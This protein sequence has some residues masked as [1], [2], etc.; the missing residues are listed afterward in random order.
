MM[1]FKQTRGGVR[2]V[3]EKGNEVAR[4]NGG[5]GYIRVV[6]DRLEGDGT[7]AGP[8]TKSVRMGPVGKLPAVTIRFAKARRRD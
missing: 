1:K 4:I 5:R 2:V 7:A 8:F 3:D 6:S